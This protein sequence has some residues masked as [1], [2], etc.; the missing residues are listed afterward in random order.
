MTKFLSFC[1]EKDGLFPVLSLANTPQVSPW[2]L[3]QECVSRTAS[4][5]HKFLLLSLDGKIP[6]SANRINSLTKEILHSY[7]VNTA[8]WRPHSTSGAGVMW[9]KEMGFTAEEIQQLGQWKNFSAFQ[10]HYLRLGVGK[11]GTKDH[12]A[13]NLTIRRCGV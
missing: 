2:H 11:K 4:E 1:K 3:M 8:H 10:A 13:Q 12:G 6:L 9:W 7:G 5:Q